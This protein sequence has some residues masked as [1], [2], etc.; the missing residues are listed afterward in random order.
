MSD[1]MVSKIKRQLDN[2]EHNKINIYFKMKLK[3][4]K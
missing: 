3:K 4:D 1:W 2:T